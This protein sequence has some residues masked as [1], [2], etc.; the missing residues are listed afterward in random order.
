MV[1]NGPRSGGIQSESD[2]VSYSS[3]S[4]NTDS[5][6]SSLSGSS[7]LMYPLSTSAS[8]A[9]SSSS[10]LG[11]SM[12][13]PPAPATHKV[14]DEIDMDFLR[15]FDAVSETGHYS[16]VSHHSSTIFDLPQPLPNGPMGMGASH[17]GTGGYDNTVG[18][19]G[20]VPSTY[21]PASAA[22]AVAAHQAHVMHQHHPHSQ[23]PTPMFAE[24]HFM[25]M[26]DSKDGYLQFG[27]DALRLGMHVAELTPAL[28]GV[29]PFGSY[30]H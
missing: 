15:N 8:S 26:H 11:V 20:H 25:K 30:Y 9:S 29:S 14:L 1:H 6:R 18:M 22:A 5:H 3:G 12:P 17:S 13:P 21:V 7:S 28:E 16:P 27:T 23:P 24:E 10:S 2:S 4:H 19:M